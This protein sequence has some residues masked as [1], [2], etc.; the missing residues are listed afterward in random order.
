MLTAREATL[1]GRGGLRPLKVIGCGLWLLSGCFGG[2]GNVPE[3]IE[4]SGTVT[5]DGQPLPDAAVNF[6]PVVQGNEESRPASGTTDT[7][8]EYSLQYSS[9]QTG[10]RPGNYRVSIS[11]Y[12]REGEDREGNH[13]AGVAEKV[14]SVYNVKTTLTAEVKADGSPLDFPLKSDAGPVIQPNP[15]T[16][17]DMSRGGDDGC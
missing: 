14:P 10:A 1:K 12:R 16:A 3:L 8:G 6:I 2:G 17:D 13:V 15:A 4:V 9:S 5:L 11:T 7:D